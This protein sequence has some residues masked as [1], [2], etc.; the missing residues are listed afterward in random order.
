MGGRCQPVR[1]GSFGT[2]CIQ[3]GVCDIYGVCMCI[4]YMDGYGLYTV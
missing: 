3:K 4:I 2:K 1:E